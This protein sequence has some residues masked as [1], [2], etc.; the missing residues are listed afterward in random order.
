MVKEIDNNPWVKI[1]RI[2]PTQRDREFL[3]YG[4]VLSKYLDSDSE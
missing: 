3:R 1:I 2:Y 4:R